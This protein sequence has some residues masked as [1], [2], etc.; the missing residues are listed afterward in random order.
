MHKA[1]E[2]IIKQSPHLKWLETNTLILGKS[3][4]YSYG[5]NING[6][7]DFDYKGTCVEPIE[8]SFGFLNNFE[9][10]ILNEPYDCT[11][12]SLKKFL[13]L[14]INSNPNCLELLFIEPEDYLYVS[15]LGQKLI[16][17]RDAFLSKKLKFTLSGYAIAQLNRLKLHKSFLDK[18]EPK[19][20]SRS[21]FGLLERNVRDKNQVEAVLATIDKEM[22]RVNFDFMDHLEDS[23]KIEVKRCMKEM[24]I[25]ANISKEDQ[26]IGVVRDFGISDSFMAVLQKEKEYNSAVKSYENYQDWKKNRNP[27]RAELEAKFN[28]DCKNASHLIR[29]INS[30]KEV[31]TTGKYLVRRPDAEFLKSIRQGAWSYDQVIEFADSSEKELNE[32]YESCII[33]PREPDRKLIDKLCIEIYK[34]FI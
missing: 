7:S 15:P 19:K 17:N 18:G 31:L 16:D 29:L 27:A 25:K 6:V 11:V 34:E 26:F 12:F 28:Y 9:Q 20:P 23:V 4:S 24:F 2:E 21:D 32:L 10:A 33:L 5:T 30:A 3:G 22:K 1:I 14:A 8:Y 13:Q